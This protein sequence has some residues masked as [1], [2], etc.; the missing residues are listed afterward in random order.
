V[1]SGSGCLRS[2]NAFATFKKC[3]LMTGGAVRTHNVRDSSHTIA[4]L[5]WPRRK[6]GSGERK[7]ALSPSNGSAGATPRRY[8]WTNSSGVPVKPRP[9]IIRRRFSNKVRH[10]GV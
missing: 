8:E 6:I 4:G 2:G 1:T 5:F 3:V 10:L 7:L 9:N